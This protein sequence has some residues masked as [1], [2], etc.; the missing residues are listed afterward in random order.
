MRFEKWMN[1]NDDETD[2]IS[3]EIEREKWNREQ[4]RHKNWMKIWT[5][6]LSAHREIAKDDHGV[7]YR[8]ILV[9]LCVIKGLYWKIVPQFNCVSIRFHLLAQIKLLFMTIVVVFSL[10]RFGHTHTSSSLSFSSFSITFLSA[11]TV[12][13]VGVRSLT[14]FCSEDS[15][16]EH[17]RS[18]HLKSPYLHFKI[19]L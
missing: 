7:Q 17:H 18:S 5:I 10:S 8:I 15:K 4:Q 9:L 12:A 1:E 19:Y 11:Q 2:K 14:L 13:R 16:P 6:N 3:N